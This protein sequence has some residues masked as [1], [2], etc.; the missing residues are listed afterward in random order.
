[1]SFPQEAFGGPASIS[2][3][4]DGKIL[5]SAG[6]TPDSGSIRKGLTRLNEDITPDDTFNPGA[7]LTVYSLAIQKDGRILAAGNFKTL[8]GEPRAGIGRLNNTTP[9]TEHL[10]FDGGS[11]TWLRGGSSPEVSRI[12]FEGNAGDDNWVKIGYAQRIDGGWYSP[13]PGIER[14]ASIRARGWIQCGIYNGSFYFVESVLQVIPKITVQP[15]FGTDSNQFALSLTG[16]PG[17]EVVV[18]AST[19]LLDWTPVSTNTFETNTLQFTDP[20]ISGYSRRFYRA[21]VP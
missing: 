11:I 5:L 1:T 16:T 19:N 15:G 6:M 18:E 8:D 10:S 20:A 17:S 9:A 2:L 3:Q 13:L 21:R 14:F 4:A 7:G 12:S